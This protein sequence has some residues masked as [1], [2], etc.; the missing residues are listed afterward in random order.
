MF[1]ITREFP[2]NCNCHLQNY[3]MNAGCNFHNRTD[4][5]FFPSLLCPPN[6]SSPSPPSI[7]ATARMGRVDGP[8]TQNRNAGTMAVDTKSGGDECPLEK[9]AKSADSVEKNSSSSPL[10]EQ[11]KK[12]GK[13]VLHTT[14]HSSSPLYPLSLG[15]HVDSILAF[16]IS[17]YVDIQNFNTHQIF[18]AFILSTLNMSR[19]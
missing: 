17:P 3:S 14:F 6:C 16:K 2:K 12:E 15:G 7:T 4:R 10:C 18:V 19:I 1:Q 5:E 9:P 11:H 8:S 13:F